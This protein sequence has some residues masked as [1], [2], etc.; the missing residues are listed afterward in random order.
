MTVSIFLGYWFVPIRVL[1]LNGNLSL[2]LS[3]LLQHHILI[4]FF[5]CVKAKLYWWDTCRVS[6]WFYFLKLRFNLQCLYI[7]LSI[8]SQCVWIFSLGLNWARWSR[9][10]FNFLHICEL[11]SFVWTFCFLWKRLFNFWIFAFI[12]WKY[13]LDRV[14]SGL[15]YAN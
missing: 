3:R 5:A 1:L 8:L 4:I 2:I 12:I 10:L 7:C 11:D 6:M 9:S 15:D 13:L 14:S